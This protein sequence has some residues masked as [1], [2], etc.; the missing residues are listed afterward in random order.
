[1]SEDVGRCISCGF[2]RIRGRQRDPTERWPGTFEV[3]WV[4]RSEPTRARL[5]VLSTHNVRVPTE[6]VCYLGIASLPEEVGDTDSNQAAL[7]VLR[8]DRKCKQ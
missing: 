8:M 3:E 2:L 7:D 1:M 4:D 5:G 6:L